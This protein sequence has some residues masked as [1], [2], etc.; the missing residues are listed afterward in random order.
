MPHS[1]RWYQD[2]LWLHQSGT[3]EFGKLDLNS[4]HFEPVA[5]CPGYLRGL[6]FAGNYALVG[7]SR[8]RHE[9]TFGGLPL[10]G[11]L[12]DKGGAAQCGVLVIDLRT[13]NIEHTLQ[14]EGAVEELYDVVTL[15]NVV[16][17]MALGFVSSEIQRLLSIESASSI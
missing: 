5:F 12:R 16:R 10:E 8:P 3:G 9:R 17:P 1:P 2:Q 11:R 6:S 4:G 7:L 14:I 13:G 15:P